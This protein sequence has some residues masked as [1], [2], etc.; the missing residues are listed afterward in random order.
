[1]KYFTILLCFL[2]TILS[3]QLHDSSE[4]LIGITVGRNTTTGLWS[5]DYDHESL[6]STFYSIEYNKPFDNKGFIIELNLSTQGVIGSDPQQ[7]YIPINPI[8]RTYSSNFI[9]LS[10]LGYYSLPLGPIS[11]ELQYGMGLQTAFGSNQN[12]TSTQKELEAL[13]DPI[14][15]T[16][17]IGL[18][19]HMRKGILSNL[20]VQARYSCAF[21]IARYPLWIRIPYLS[22]RFDYLQLGVGY[23]IPL[24]KF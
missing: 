23:S 19:L 5:L 16:N 13:I 18:R 7:T 1:M 14:N 17:S 10:A 3:A 12:F 4:S 15:I 8:N 2:S 6:Q 24:S 11:A 20:Y 22:Y 9:S 21:N